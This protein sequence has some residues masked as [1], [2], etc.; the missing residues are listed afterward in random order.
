[1]DNSTPFMDLFV[2]LNQQHATLHQQYYNRVKTL[3]LDSPVNAYLFGVNEVDDEYESTLTLEEWAIAQRERKMLP[4]RDEAADLMEEYVFSLVIYRDGIPGEKGPVIL[5]FTSAD[6]VRRLEE[7][8][9]VNLQV[10]VWQLDKAYTGAV[11]LALSEL[12]SIGDNYTA[13]HISTKR[14]ETVSEAFLEREKQYTKIFGIM[15][16]SPAQ[17]NPDLHYFPFLDDGEKMYLFEIRPVHGFI[18]RNQPYYDVPKF[19]SL[20][21][22][23][24]TGAESL[25]AIA[26]RAKQNPN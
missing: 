4:M 1:M 22:V 15:P 9:F 3:L 13:E 24:L 6:V 23:Y 25:N 11:D 26:A 20:D 8:S 2:D 14:F 21:T 16:I 12:H 17:Y 7:F 5:A 18:S 10:L 19:N